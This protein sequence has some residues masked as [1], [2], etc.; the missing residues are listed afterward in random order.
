MLEEIEKIENEEVEELDIKLK[1]A[2]GV[3]EKLTNEVKDL[4]NQFESASE[5]LAQRDGIETE[6]VRAKVISDQ[7]IKSLKD[8]NK[9]CNEELVK[10]TVE[11]NTSENSLNLHKKGKDILENQHQAELENVR[12]E[13]EE[14][15]LTIQ[16]KD[17]L[18]K[19]LSTEN[20]KSNEKIEIFEIE[21]DEFEKDSERIS[22]LGEDVRSNL[23]EELNYTL[24][25]LN[26]L[27]VTIVRKPLRTKLLS[28]ITEENAYN[29]II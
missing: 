6:F 15:Y 10:L 22:I 26:F 27:N 17:A 8:E 13:V 3:I 16:E 29:S 23:Y 5:S 28:K 14:L 20:E 19:N 25:I 1:V 12:K 11:K 21:K 24:K 2:T 18:L 9:K 7:L 4:N